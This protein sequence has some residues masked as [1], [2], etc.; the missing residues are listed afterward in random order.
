[1]YGRAVFL[2]ALDELHTYSALRYVERSPVEAGM[3]D[4]AE[5][6]FLSIAAHHCGLV[7]SETLSH[8]ANT[9]IDIGQADWSDF[10]YEG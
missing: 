10:S 7:K 5:D 3:V 4:K 8:R 2:S 1:M 9:L 6:Y